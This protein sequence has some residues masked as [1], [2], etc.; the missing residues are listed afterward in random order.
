[1]PFK[2]PEK[3]RAYSK[4]WRDANIE[5]QRQVER[6]SRSRPEANTPEV[7]EELAQK[8]RIWQKN[9]LEKNRAAVLRYRKLYPERI[10]ESNLK[11]LYGI[12]KAAYERLLAAQ[13]NGCAICGACPKPGKRL[14][15]DHDH[16]SGKIRG[17]LCRIHNLGLGHFQDDPILLEQGAAYLRRPIPAL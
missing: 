10:L 12:T 2:D 6:R 13:G 14:H 1:M 5:K 7:K 16:Q 8:K 4:E 11:C 9:N 17:L 15:V 3:R